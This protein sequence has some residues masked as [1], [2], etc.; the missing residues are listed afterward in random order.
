MHLFN[1]CRQ[2]AEG[3]IKKSGIE[4]YQLG[5]FKVFLRAGQMAVLD[6]QRTEVLSRAAV[7]LQRFARG[8][9]A[10]RSY[11]QALESVLR[12]QAWGRGMLARKACRALRQHRA[13]TTIQTA[14]R[15]HKIRQQYQA[16]VH[17]ITQ[18][19]VSSGSMLLAGSPVTP[20]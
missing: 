20:A 5:T 3:I 1:D 13:A 14:Y 4:G 7:S 15:R 9:L 2:I 8:F 17:T 16:V 12:L 19:Q 10:R 11:Q 18:L 6:K